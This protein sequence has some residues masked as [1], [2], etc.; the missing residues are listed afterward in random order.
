MRAGGGDSGV[1]SWVCGCVNEVCMV[2]T[3]CGD[4][5]VGMFGRVGGWVSEFWKS[6]IVYML[7]LIISMSTV[8]LTQ[9]GQKVD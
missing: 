1:C 5:C 7:I 8:C 2:V 3:G 6:G 4:G 9:F